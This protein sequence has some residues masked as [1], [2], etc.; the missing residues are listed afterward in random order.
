LHST[1]QGKFLWPEVGENDTTSGISEQEE[2]SKIFPKKHFF[3]P[4]L[5]FVSPQGEVRHT[6]LSKELN[7]CGLKFI[8]GR[9][10]LGVG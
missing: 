7:W 3:D 6:R 10:P 2:N 9:N 1:D 4:F 5:F 8:S